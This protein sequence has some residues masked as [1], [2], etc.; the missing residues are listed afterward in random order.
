MLPSFHRPSDLE[1]ATLFHANNSFFGR[2]HII[3]GFMN[4]IRCFQI[5]ESRSYPNLQRFKHST[6]SLLKYIAI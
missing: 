1:S 3:V 4:V 5:E 6:R 2:S